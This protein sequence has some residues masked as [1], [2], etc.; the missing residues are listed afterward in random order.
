MIRFQTPHHTPALRE[1]TAARPG[2][3]RVGR[4]VRWALVGLVATGC[5]DAVGPPIPASVAISPGAVVLGEVG[6]S[7]R[8]GAV[9]FDAAG[10]PIPD[11]SVEWRSGNPG[12]AAISVDGTVRGVANGETVVTAR[13]GG[14]E[15]SATVRVGLPAGLGLMPLGPDT[16][17]A[18]VAGTVAL[19]VRVESALGTPYPGA[20]VRWS[21]APGS[22]SITP[23]AVSDASGLVE[24]T[25][26]LGTTAGTHTAFATLETGSDL[27]IVSFSATAT[28]GAA[29]SV[30]LSADSVLLSGTG[31][32]VRLV[33]VVLDAWGNAADAGEVSWLSRAPGVAGVDPAG[34]VTAAGPGTGWIVAAL[35]APLDSVRVSLVPRGAI[36]LTFDDGWRSVYENAWPVLQDFP[37]IR[38]NVGVYT[39][40]VGWPGYLT[41]AHLAEF[42]EAGW[43]MVSHTVSHDSLTTL[44]APELD[45][46]LRDSQE[47]LRARG[48]RGTDILIAPYHD[49]TDAERTAAATYYRA[50]R[51]I[52]A[53]ATVPETLAPW[54]PD[55]PFHL[56][57]IP[58]DDLPYTTSEGRDRLRALLQRTL[59]EGRFLDVF[60]HQVPPENVD[61]LRAMLEV[62]EEFGDRVLPY[63][64]LFPAA[65]RIVR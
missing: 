15:G 65:P 47:W 57:G 64:E 26:T 25:W 3:G 14:A 9:A 62:M 54:M 35:D 42:H 24:A 28:P 61:A 19:S 5:S 13:A 55:Q 22:G 40:A 33:P 11:A 12:V 10:D 2:R 46:E 50:A 18:P 44:T 4:V 34:T 6:A 45:H 48:F 37:A 27:E 36:T 58:A 53:H 8:L 30:S 1:R 32:E 38:A 49:L 20:A 39:E 52:S 29:A 43:S 21:A 17:T 56:T 23:V 60:L 16:A 7:A 51:G 31:E 63:H 59:D 41:E